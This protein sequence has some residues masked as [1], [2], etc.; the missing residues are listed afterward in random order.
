[1]KLM[2]LALWGCRWLDRHALISSSKSSFRIW[3]S[4]NALALQQFLWCQV[5]LSLQLKDARLGTAP[6]AVWISYEYVQTLSRTLIKL[7]SNQ[8][9]MG[10][11]NKITS[12][13]INI[14]LVFWD[15]SLF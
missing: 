8:A 9:N 6:P 11:L 5:Q 13:F 14:F 4:E 3:W 12:F 2:R 10:I 15:F 1:M 7:L